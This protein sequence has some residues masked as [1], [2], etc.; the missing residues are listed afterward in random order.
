MSTFPY[1]TTKQVARLL[2]FKTGR[3]VLAAASRYGIK[4]AV[5]KPGRSY[6]TKDQVDAIR[7]GLSKAA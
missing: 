1:L 4:P 5:T 7:K 6:W 3:G 2:K